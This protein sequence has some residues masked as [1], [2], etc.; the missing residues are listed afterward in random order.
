[1]RWFVLQGYNLFYFK[2][3]GVCW[4]WSGAHRTH[5]DPRQADKPLGAINIVGCRTA[6]APREL[7]GRDFCFELESG[8]DGKVFYI[9]C[10][11]RRV[12]L[13]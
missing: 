2:T 9:A 6:D 11:V 3:R 13:R 5:T 8:G 7:V 10:K 4:F 12:L 1:M